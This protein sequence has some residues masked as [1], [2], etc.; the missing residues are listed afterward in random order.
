VLVEDAWALPVLH[1]GKAGK[2][3]ER[4]GRRFVGE[5]GWFCCN[6]LL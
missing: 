1:T 3:R 2:K 4:E 5:P 6:V